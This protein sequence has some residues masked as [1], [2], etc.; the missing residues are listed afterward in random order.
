[1]TRVKKRKWE[2]EEVQADDDEYYGGSVRCDSTFAIVF[3]GIS[4]FNSRFENFVT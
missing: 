1:M 4:A 3:P 2:E